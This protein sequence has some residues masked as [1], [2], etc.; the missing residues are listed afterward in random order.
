MR[1]NCAGRENL[2]VIGT[3]MCEFAH[4]SAD[5]PRTVGNAVA[6]IQ[7]QLDVLG[8]SGH[9][10]RSLADRHIRARDIHTGP[11]EYSLGNGVAHGD[12]VE[13]AID[14]N[15]AYRRK[16]SQQGDPGIRDSSISGLDCSHAQRNQGLSVVQVG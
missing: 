14:A 8:Q 12:I 13:G 10:A 3:K 6:K 5:L 16:A 2:D 7:R 1:E 9:R 11:D 15:V 4:N